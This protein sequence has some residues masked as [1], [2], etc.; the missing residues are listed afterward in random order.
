MA[1]AA[2]PVRY[3]IAPLDPGAHLFRVDCEVDDPDPAGQALSLPA[4]IP[5]SYMIRDF[6]RHVVAFRAWCG[7]EPLAVAR[8]DKQTWRCAPADGPLRVTLEVYAWDLSVR[9]AHLD[10]THG[11]FNGPC[12]LPAV[13][14]RE[15]RPC[16]LEIAL[17]DDPR[18]SGWRVATA[19]TRDG[20]APWSPG[21][22]RAESYDALIDHPVEMGHFS[23]ERF[24]AGGVTHHLAV[25][26]AHRGDLSRMA[27]DLARI[28]EAHIGLFGGPAPLPEYLFLLTV[29]GSGYGGLE[30]RASSSL[31]ASRDDLPRPGDPGVGEGYRSLL[32]LCSHEYF[33]TW[34]VKRIK[35]AAFVPYDLSREVHTT[36]LW[37]FEGATS[38]YD[39]LAL[40]RAGVI[41]PGSYLE[42]LGQAATRVWRGAGRHRQSIAES[43]FDAWT[44]FYKQD[45]NAPNAIVSY[46][47]KGALVVLALDLLLRRRSEGRTTLDDLVRMLWERYGRT[48]AGV[49]ED[50]VEAAAAELAGGGLEDFFARCVHGTEDPPLADLLADVGVRWALRPARGQ[51]DKGGRPGEGGA[52]EPVTLGLRTAA[53]PGAARVTHVRAGGPGEAAGI[54]PGDLIVAV[55]GLR[56]DGEGFDRRE[57]ALAPGVEVPVHLFRQDALLTLPV[58]PR[59]APADTVS[60]ALDPEA[61]PEALARRAAWLGGS[62]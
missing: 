13:A 17:G 61:P 33:H 41:S 34:N 29:T 11:Y 2:T 4:W 7:K 21:R 48:G 42:L 54:A 25:T 40:V 18:C 27:G 62:P 24:E 6:A 50:G 14:G 26:G 36:L 20:A 53:A 28:C 35:P 3:R 32:G 52:T 30:H 8:V 49:P 12:V 45:E 55:D 56:V 51:G 57:A 9:G 5:G 31:L 37:W 47:S 16:T 15:A 19:M 1:D 58:T 10:T 43:S 38:Y 22:Y 46:Y 60:L 23:L 44:R 39:D 59:P